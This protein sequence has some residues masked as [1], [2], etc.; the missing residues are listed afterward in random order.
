LSFNQKCNGIINIERL[1]T[2]IQLITGYREHVC[3]YNYG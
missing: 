2:I 1:N 3:I